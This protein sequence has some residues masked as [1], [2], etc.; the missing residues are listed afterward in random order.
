[1]VFV[2]FL[3]TVPAIVMPMT[4]GW[5]KLSGYMMVVC[6][7]FTMVIG[8]DIWFETLKTRENLFVI[9]KK[10]PSTT[11]SLLQQEAHIL[12]TDQPFHDANTF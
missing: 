10:Q 11:Q 7:F 3:L 12:I 5:L 9:W 1:M 4:R 6:A 2:T 8:L